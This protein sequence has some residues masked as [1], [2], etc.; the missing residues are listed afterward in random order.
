[1]PTWQDASCSLLGKDICIV[2]I[3][4]FLANAERKYCY[5][6]IYIFYYRIEINFI[7]LLKISF[8]SL[9]YC[10]WKNG[11][12]MRGGLCKCQS[13]LVVIWKASLN[14]IS[15]LRAM[16]HS[17]TLCLQTLAFSA[18]L[19]ICGSFSDRFAVSF[20]VYN[21]CF[22]KESMTLDS[23]K[24][25]WIS[26]LSLAISSSPFSSRSLLSLHPSDSSH[27]STRYGHNYWGVS[28]KCSS[29]TASSFSFFFIAVVLISNLHSP[30][31]WHIP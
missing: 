29:K 5:V 4:H 15:P 7:L 31:F 23:I 18:Q 17:Q 20:C 3:A 12:L 2:V 24:Q 22:S 14:T 6:N 9:L 25:F 30:T 13:Q 27:P 10:T 16:H 28:L 8:W 26:T 21:I 19:S 1:M 11:C